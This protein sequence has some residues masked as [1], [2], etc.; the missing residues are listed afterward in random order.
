MP[1]ITVLIA[2]RNAEKTLAETLESLAAQTYTDFD[3]LLV[4][5][6]SSDGTQEVANA[7]RSRLRLDLLRL[8]KNAGVAGALNHGLAQIQS[9]YI[10]RL[11]A[12]DIALPT[13]L[14]KQAAFLDAR[15][16]VAV[17]GSWMDMFYDD[18][19]QNSRILAKPLEDAAIKTA[20]VQYCSMSHGSS[21]FR[22][23][24]FQDV[25][26]F[27][28]RL[29]FAE[30]YDIWCR[31]ALLGKQYAN[32]PEALTR[33]RQ[34]GGQVGQ[35]KRQLQYERDLIIKRKYISALLGGESSG[36]LAEFFSLLTMFTTRAIALQ[37]VQQSMPLLFKLGRKVYD[38]KLYSEIVA[39]CIGR[40][41]AA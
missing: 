15:S 19:S 8:D 26:V 18:A 23:S 31:G 9:D 38:E 35:Q 34:H 5:D 36:N 17:C 7:F 6:E 10:A 24:F 41:L 33:Y 29:D 14:E 13:R 32:L 16:D 4:D 40:H 25:G 27:D 20:L 22:R 37:V 28:L 3:V 30:D 12:D 39:A 2:A 1:K 11:D 21:T